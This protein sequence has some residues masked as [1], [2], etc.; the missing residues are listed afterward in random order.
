MRKLCDIKVK[1]KF[2]LEHATKVKR[3]V[4]VQLYSFFKLNRR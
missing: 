3:G 4:E 2:S 1:V